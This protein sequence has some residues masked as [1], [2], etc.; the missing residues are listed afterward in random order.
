M[1]IPG[2]RMAYVLSVVNERSGLVDSDTILITDPLGSDLEMF[3][4]DSDGSGSPAIFTD[5]A[6]GNASGLSYTFLNLSSFADDIDFSDDG[7]ATFSYVPVPDANG[8]DSNVTNIRIAPKGVF[9]AADIGVQP[10]FQIEFH[11]RV[12]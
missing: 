1:A 4:G 7:G 2:A 10:T 9:R 11:V 3:V 8:F 12:K 6:G 5:G